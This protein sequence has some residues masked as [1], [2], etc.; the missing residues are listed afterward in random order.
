[1]IGAAMITSVVGGAP[2]SQDRG[3]PDRRPNIVIIVA[4]DMGYSDM[5]AF[6]GEIRTPNLDRL[7]M[8]GMRFTQFYTH[9]SCSPTRSMLLSGVD[10]HINGLGNMSEWTA[11]NQVGI[12][13]Y[14]GALSDRVST[15]PEFL[16][17]GGY[18]TYMVGKWHLGKQPHQIPRA[19]GFERDFSLLDG[20]GSYWDMTSFTAMSP[21]ST[22]TEDGYY[23]SGLPKDYYATRTYTDRMID[24]IDEGRAD[25]R[26]FFA[27]VAHQ[28]PHDPYHLPREWRDRY[29][30]DYDQ[31]WDAVR[32]ARLARQIELGIVPD[33]TQ[34]SE[35]MWMVPPPLVLA[36]AARALQGRKMEL[37]AGLVENLDFNIGRLLEYLREVGEYDNTLFMFF[38]DNGAEGTDLFASIAGTPGTLNYLFAAANWSQTHPKSWGDPGSYVGYGP[39]WAQVSMTPFSQYKGWLA[40]GGVRNA[41]VVSGP[42]VEAPPGTINHGITHV[43]DIMPTVL[44]IAGIAHPSV[45]EGTRNAA[46]DRQIVDPRTGRR[47]EFAPIRRGLPGLGAFRQ[48][49]AAAGRVEASLA[50]PAFRRRRM[51]TLQP[52][53]R[54]GRA[55]RS[56][57]VS[58]RQGRRAVGA[59]GIVRGR[60]QRHPA[61][62]LPVR[63]TGRHHAAALP[64]QSRVSAD[65]LPATVRA[66][67]ANGPSPGQ[68]I[69]PVSRPA[70]KNRGLGCRPV[71]FALLLLSWAA[72]HAS[73]AAAQV[74]PRF[75]WKALSGTNAMIVIGQSIVAN[76]NP[77]DPGYTVQADIAVNATLATV[78]YARTFAIGGRAAFAAMLVPM[79]RL[80][81]TATL[82]GRSF[83][84]AASGYGDPLLEF[85]VNVIGPPAI[86]NIPDM[87]RYE[88]GFSVDIIAD[89]GLPIGEYDSENSLNLGQNRWYGRIGAPVVWQLGAWVPGRRTTIELVPSLWIFGP[90]NDL[91]GNTLKT[92]PMFQL[93]AHLTRDFTAEMWGSL[94]GVWV[95]GGQASLNDLLEGMPLSTLGVG[96]TFGYHLNENLQLTAGYLATVNDGKPDDLRMDGFKISLVYGWHPLIEGVGRLGAE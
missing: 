17:Q 65:H 79:G 21:R 37:Y 14:E 60:Q 16:L 77:L 75:Y 85:G 27:Y 93:D 45:E 88:P 94:D 36:P 26:P 43:A 54:S 19:R 57:G 24:F 66:A 39:A 22:F 61:E 13:G 76:A 63:G 59:L 29:V 9:A 84:D 30:R 42:G 58:S 48:P 62:P 72:V 34:L 46:P 6:G 15:L 74:P 31:G 96:L 53:R 90:N 83:G 18:H 92:D 64:R 78:G 38:G 55:P 49:F 11:P 51:G 44:E 20:G 69:G 28:A 25:G 40:E 50:V 1:M 67:S 87:L 95:T 80:S 10:T 5:G 68:R 47:V 86:R 4:D 32:Q 91:G 73:P 35:R 41:L 56:L 7:A 33:G 82:A 8:G 23:L 52:R 70:G 81:G 89:L 71:L 2:A 3:L 12:A